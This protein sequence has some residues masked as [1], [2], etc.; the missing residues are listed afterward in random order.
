MATT[1]PLS[2]PFRGIAQTKRCR[3]THL[4]SANAAKSS[5]HIASEVVYVPPLEAVAVLARR[6][7]Y[8]RQL[9][10]QVLVQLY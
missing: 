6:G 5:D 1:C 4:C 3:E 8:L 2:Y 10:V 9:R 7:N